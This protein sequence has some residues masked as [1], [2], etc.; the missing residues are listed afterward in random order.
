MINSKYSY[1]F[2]SPLKIY[3]GGR[4][5]VTDPNTQESYYIPRNR[6]KRSLDGDLVR[7]S[8]FNDNWGYPRAYLDKIIERKSNSY[9][10]KVQCKGKKMLA[11]I[12]PFQSKQIIIKRNVKDYQNGDL[13]RIEIEN[14]REN[15]KSAYAKVIKILSKHNEE[16]NDFDYVFHKYGLNKFAK[17]MINQKHKDEFE[18][19][20][21]SNSSNR[22]DLTNM[23]TI[24]IDPEEAKDFD[25][26][27]SLICRKDESDIYIH[28]ADVSSYVTQGSDI[29]RNAHE[30]GNSYYFPEQ[31]LHMLPDELS[32]D[33]CSLL[34]KKTR[35]A[36]TVKITL[37][38]KLNVIDSKIFETLIR[39]NKK[40]S[41]NEVQK[42]IDDNN[43]ENKFYDILL[44]L[45]NLTQLLKQKR[46]SQSGLDIQNNDLIFKHN[47][48]GN[49]TKIQVHQ[50]RWMDSQ[51]IIEECMLLANKVAA[52][53]MLDAFKSTKINGIYRNHAIPSNKNEVF[54]K[55]LVHYISKKKISNSSPN[56]AKFL[57]DFLKLFQ[58]KN[59]FEFLPLLVMKRMQ[60]ANY[61]TVSN[62]HYGLGFLNYTHFTSPIRRYSDLMVHRIIKGEILDF[63]LIQKSIISSN[64]NEKK[65]QLSERE[66]K[67][68]KG[69]RILE[70]Q[71]SKIF[72]GQ[73]LEIKGSKIFIYEPKTGIIGYLRKNNLPSDRYILS[74]NKLVLTGR[75][76]DLRYSVGQVVKIKIKFVNLFSQE[77][78]FELHF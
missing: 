33:Y 31:T 40:F 10:A 23:T 34:P 15:H 24:T 4:G 16:S 26:A 45:R 67:N 61:S 22:V 70:S 43:I 69:L 51:T 52:Q 42:V 14:W 57:N 36:F 50:K 6:L 7:V 65:S 20:L 5:C 46:L 8:I 19:V 76:K 64:E 68:L 55:D 18:S 54:L 44:K 59:N 48:D 38:N 58:Q 78:S 53:K 29:D 2:N 66:Y 62:G 74:G 28:I 56:N 77:V 11:S 1:Y 13:V 49:D 63:G 72:S 12:Y 39:S 32:T 37:D 41:Y 73:I 17:H 71:K 3:M 35:L 27:L 25:D 9:V 30:R 21:K 60:K 75:Y 47:N